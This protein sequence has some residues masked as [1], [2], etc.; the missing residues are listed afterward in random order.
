MKFPPLL[1]HP[2][3][4]PIVMLICSLLLYVNTFS[5]TWLMDDFPVIVNNSDIRSISNFIANANP[6]RPLREIT[7][8]FDFFLF[9]LDPWGYHFQNIFWHALNCW[10]V[11]LLAVRLNLGGTVAWLSSLLFLVHPIHVEVVANSSHR[12]DSL[13]LA[14]ILMAFLSYMSAIEQK[15]LTR[16]IIWLAGTALLWLIAFFAKGNAIVFP[17]LVLAYEYTLVPKG[18]RIFVKWKWIVP[19]LCIVSLVGMMVWY[20][21]ISSLPSFKMAIIAAFIK[22]DSLVS[23]SVQAYILMLLKSWLFLVSKLILPFNLSMEYIY[24]VPLSFLDYWVV[25]ALVLIPVICLIAYRWKNSSPSSF[26]LIVISAIL[27]LP[28]A[29]IFWHFAYF[30]ADRYMY[31]PSASLCILTVLV[32]ERALC[33]TRKFLVSGWLLIICFFAI[34]S[35]QQTRVWHNE[36]SLYSHMLKISPRSL[37]AMVGLASAYYI[38]KDYDLSSAYAQQAMERDFTDA[39]PYLIL[40]NINF[41]HKRLNEALLLLL[42]AQEK[43]PLLPE[44]HNALGLVYDD[45]G[46]VDQAIASFMTALKLRPVYIEAHTNLAVAYERANRL[47]DAELEL[48]KALALDVRHVPAWFNLGVVRYKNNDKQGARI[49]F[50]EALKR[51]PFHVDALTNLSIV[52]KET[53]DEVCY[54]DANRRLGSVVPIADDKQ[55]QSK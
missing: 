5:G 19:F 41:T 7:C 27:W 25:S 33:V 11:Y 48:G 13:A 42:E 29:N 52:C 6:G 39:R 20:F 26:F 10:L 32:S 2:L 45:M 51:D 55:L 53:G 44:V 34:L 40:G 49:A 50:S 23:F 38:E 8:L 1:H 47:P 22:T 43:G 30:A 4:P 16:R 15:L 35:W 21:Y 37:E 3:L 12:K 14:F 36:I 9:G 54:N 28:T 31:A 18:D 24:P 46:K 17:A